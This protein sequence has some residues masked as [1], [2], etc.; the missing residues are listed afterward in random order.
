MTDE[1]LE[2]LSDLD[3]VS[4]Q[5]Q[6]GDFRIIADPEDEFMLLCQ[7]LEDGQWVNIHRN[8]ILD[9]EATEALLLCGRL[10]MDG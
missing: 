6:M 1:L 4:G 9:K 7:Q 2:M 3:G 5:A 10:L 8:D